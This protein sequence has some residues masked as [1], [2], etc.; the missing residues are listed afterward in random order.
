MIVKVCGMREPENI[1]RVDSLPVQWM[2]FIF[3]PPSKRYVDSV[4]AHMPSRAKR[5]GVFV[6]ASLDFI[7]E[8][9][10]TFGLDM[11]QLHGQETP[12]T[13]D[14]VR[15]ATGCAVI[16]AFG[17]NEDT[18]WDNIHRYD[19]HADYLLFD[20]HCDTAGGSGRT[21]DHSLLHHYEGKTPF[22]LSGGIGLDNVGQILK[23]NHPLMAGIDLNSKFETAPALKSVER[24][25]QFLEKL[26][27]K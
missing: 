24:L 17:I 11:I 1:L 20:T 27:T 2:G 23:I 4:P 7:A 8:R 10:M 6:N 21:F 15:Q 26:T 9:A 22:V 25:Q 5:V 16:K 14:H 18:C 12:M 19:G 3:Y 13:C